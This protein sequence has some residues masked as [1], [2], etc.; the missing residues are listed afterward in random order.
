[1]KPW[2]IVKVYERQLQAAEEETAV[3]RAEIALLRDRAIAGGNISEATARSI[4]V[5]ARGM[6]AAEA[7]AARVHEE[8]CALKEELAQR[9]SAEAHASLQRQVDLLSRRL[10]RVG[11]PSHLGAKSA[12]GPWQSKKGDKGEPAE[13]LPRDVVLELVHQSCSMSGCDDP[14]LLPATVR[15]LQRGATASEH[16]KSF[17]DDVCGIVFGASETVHPWKLPPG[18]LGSVVPILK[19]WV[20]RL[21]TLDEVE[22]TLQAVQRQLARRRQ[23]D[24]HDMLGVKGEAEDIKG[25]R[26]HIV[27]SVMDLVDAEL[28]TQE[29][30]PQESEDPEGGRGHSRSVAGGA[31]GALPG[32]YDAGTPDRKQ[33]R[34]QWRGGRGRG[35]GRR[36]PAA[37]VSHI[38]AARRGFPEVLIY[39]PPCSTSSR[40]PVP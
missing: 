2:Q 31:V 23:R 29:R 18:D 27:M 40:R 15:K 13:R 6:A 30:T 1:M 37:P 17:A 20:T 14:L 19:S 33:D 26:R 7:N 36:P 8:N 34:E 9:P 21:E 35:R 28:E 3:A 38:A 22:G 12:H 4:Q 16:L 32:G 5:E 25:H 39:A 11:G 10:R 24:T